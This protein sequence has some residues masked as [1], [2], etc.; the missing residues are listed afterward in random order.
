MH[1]LVRLTRFFFKLLIPA[2]GAGLIMT[3]SLY[4]YLSPKLPPV[5]T[6]K[7]VK[8]QIPLR[9]F[10]QDLQ[11][12][13][14]F[15]E[16]RRSPINFEQIPPLFVQAILSAED[17][18]FYTHIGVDFK[19]LLRAALELVSTGS[20]QSGGSTITMQ[21]ARNFFLTREQSFVRK[22]NEI[23][24]AL[25]IEDEISKNDILTLYA[26]KIYLG[27]RAYGV[28]AAARVYYGKSIE[29]L[30]LPQLAMIAG[31]PKAPSTFN[32]LANPER[33]LGRRNWILAR[34][35]KLGHIDKATYTDAVMAPVDASYH[36][37]LVDFDAPYIAEMARQEAI[38]Q[39]GLEAYTNGYSV[40][41]TIDSTLQ[42]KAVQAVRAG[43]HA[44]DWRHGYRGPEKNL[45]DPTTWLPTLRQTPAY[46]ETQPAIVTALDDTQMSIQLA[47]GS[48]ATL[49]WDTSLKGLRRY[50]TENSRSAPIA[51]PSDIFTV[52]DLVRVV[53]T[54]GHWQLTQVPAAEA[55][56]VALAPENGAIK[57]L[58]GGYDFNRSHFNRVTQGERQPGSNF[59][60]F[61]YATAL[62][63]GMTAATVINDAPVVFDDP[64]LE[65]VWRPEND[66]GKFY[67][68]TR[69]RTA[70][71]L[72]RNLV[73][74]R[75]LRSLGIK[76]AIRGLQNFGFKSD[77]LPKNLSL[78]L[79]THAL[80]PMKIA[81]G[82]TVFAN[83]GFKVEPFL[84]DR[85]D[86]QEGNT[87]YR[88]N[89]ITV[90]NDCDEVFDT[91][92]TDGSNTPTDSEP[93][94][95]DLAVTDA[96]AAPTPALRPAPRV[97]DERVVYIVDSILKDVIRRGTGTKAQALKRGD[98][99]GKTGTT[100][101]PRDAWFSG[102]NPT[103][104]TTVWVGFDG[105]EPLGRG[106]Y[107][108][109]AAL[110]IWMDF[111]GSALAGKPET[112]PPQPD[113][114]VSVRINPATG[115]RAAPGDTDAIFELFLRENA[116]PPLA[117]HSTPSGHQSVPLPQ[118]IF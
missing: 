79:G 1:F 88:A 37:P 97:M 7:T 92:N 35:Y 98:L 34:M 100:N 108:G 26:N 9:V 40:I 73:S 29:E 32:P 75:V 113:G 85:I 53:A 80:T 65:S 112:Y 6:L 38:A 81:T 114:L 10:S 76:N 64:G 8:L 60:P 56:L 46:G 13:G 94:L 93:H 82:Y 106:E 58:V 96:T 74:I 107:G 66:S 59:K 19:G 31:L 104:V 24:L 55:G 4:M 12:I 22:F 109:S 70:L 14:E 68:P 57:A 50:V 43:L 117:S 28:Q 52:G 69:L 16:N 67:G 77:E 87:V 20:I 30:N 91:S 41:T 116:P 5:E 61:I 47:D 49:D 36:G 21:V 2:M 48:N 83:G 105:N 71:Y 18:A 44:Y 72:S 3:A 25:R 103:I 86:D 95:S 17:D 90:C 111:M 99:A 51:T 63:K 39:L 102:Y 54:N 15:G 42:K 45:P 62:T 110:P 33:A 89:P 23:L 11:L 27:N 118:D 84:I 101:G 115:Q 78:A